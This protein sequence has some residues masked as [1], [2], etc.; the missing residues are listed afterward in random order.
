MESKTIEVVNN[1]GK[2]LAPTNLKVAKTLIKREKAVW[3]VEG[4]KLKLLYMKSDFKKLKKEI[5]KEEGRICYIC[6]KVISKDEPATIDH[7]YPKSRYG[8]DT[9]DN[10]RCCCKKC[11]DNKGNKSIVEY[12]DYIKRN[13]HTYDYIS[14]SSIARLEKVYSI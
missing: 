6:N 4:V 7:V 12:L 13:M 14:L 8:K 9:R 5:I 11:N 1:N 3:I 10:L 2:S